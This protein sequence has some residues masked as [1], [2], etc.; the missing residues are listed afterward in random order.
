MLHHTR[1]VLASGAASVALVAAA[2]APVIARTADPT[3]APPGWRTSPTVHAATRATMTHVTD[4]RIARHPRFDRVV[5]DIDG[6]LPA[7]SIRYVRRLLYDPSG[8]PVPL[9]G[10]TKVSLSLRP[11]SAHN[12]AGRSVYDGPRLT[13]V[14]LPTLR[15]VALT[16]D[17]EGVVS[18]GFT[19]DRKAPYRIFTLRHPDRVVVDFHH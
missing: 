16:G 19:T 7:Y 9:H 5:V 12:R 8:K 3:T 11:A 2:A 14:H 18:F 4:L 17:F 13:Q 10:R 15:G 1:L 6:R